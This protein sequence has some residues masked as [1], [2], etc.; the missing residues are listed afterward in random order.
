MQLNTKH[1]GTMEVDEKGII[2]FPHGLPGFDKVK[3]FILLGA[4]EDDLPFKWLQSVDLQELAFVMVDPFYIRKDYDID[5]DDEVVETMEIE[6][7]KDIMVFS[8]VVIPDDA[9]KMTVN[10]KA[11]VIINTEK[12]K[13]MQIVLD[14]DKYSVRHYILEELR[15]QE[16]AADVGAH[17]E[18]RSIHCNR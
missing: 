16:V 6:S 9:S 10:L 4:G 18:E 2:D 11:P 14:T 3:R 7:P 5:I 17:K 13:G 12:R 1:F 15:R 8:I